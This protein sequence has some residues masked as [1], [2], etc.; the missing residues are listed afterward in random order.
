[1]KKLILMAVIC[2][3]LLNACAIFEKNQTPPPIAG[4]VQVDPKVL[5]P[6]ATLQ[7]LYS[8][9]YED[10]ASNYLQTI[11]LYG[12]CAIRQDT[13]ITTIRKLTETK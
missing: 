1:M 4:K 9:T 11:Q 5:Q 12:E 7:P 13:S 6:C 3:P 10:I 8:A 2:L